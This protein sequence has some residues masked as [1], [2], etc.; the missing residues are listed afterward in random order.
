MFIHWGAYAVA[1]RGEWVMNRER[2]PAEEYTERY[3]KSWRAENYDP[4]AWAQLALDAGMGYVVLTTRHHD[5]FSLWGTAANDFNAVKLGPQRDLLTPYVEALRAAGLKVGFYY[6]PASW[7]HP[8]YP[9]AFFRDWPA[10]NDWA[11]EAARQRFIAFYRAQLEEL[12]T[13]FGKID[14]LWFDGCIP[15][16]MD[17]DETLTMVRKLQPGI[18]V[19]NRLGKPYDV[20]CSE[21]AI[22]PAPPGQPWEACLTL[23]DNWGYH[24]GDSNWK[25]PC[26]VVEMLLTCAEKGGNLLINIGPHADGTVPEESVRILRET[27][28]WLQRNR[29]AVTASE[30]HPFSWNNT[31][32]PITARGNRA[33]LHFLKQPQGAFCWGEAKNRVL[34][35]RLLVD[36][37][38]VAFH[39]EGD[40]L[41]LTDLPKPL[42]DTP[43]TTV[44][45]EL[46]GPPEAI[47][48]QTSFWIPG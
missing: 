14:Y 2:I 8:D 7:T 30:R 46:D 15:E 48:A 43:A 44:E 11:D 24:A 31:A 36:G 41:Y 12:L 6:S 37:T 40:R 1:A 39:Q 35:A 17:G 9:G 29:A 19:N 20:M 28:A 33:Y 18:A 38:P 21:Q 42:P 45:L 16:N 5:G 13:G 10:E 22:V 26:Q 25:Q 34:A 27:G 4:A 32:R 23:N 47:T 3:V